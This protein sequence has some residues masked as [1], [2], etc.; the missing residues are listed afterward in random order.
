M[1]AVDEQAMNPDLD[2]EIYLA[3]QMWANEVIEELEDEVELEM[4]FAECIRG[5]D[6]PAV[7]MEEHLELVGV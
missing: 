4:H 6:A 3:E 7:E 2:G 5:N 1:S